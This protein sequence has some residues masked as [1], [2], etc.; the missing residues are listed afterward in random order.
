MSSAKWRPLCLSFNVLT[1]RYMLSHMRQ[2]IGLSMVALAIGLPPLPSHSLKKWPIVNRTWNKL[3]CHFNQDTTPFFEENALDN[4]VCKQP[5]FRLHCVNRPSSKCSDA[6]KEYSIN[7][8]VV[9]LCFSQGFM[10]SISRVS[11]SLGYTL[12]YWPLGV[13]EIILQVISWALPVKLVFGECPR[14]PL[15]ICQYWFR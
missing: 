8:H 12:T 11:G 13:M 7:V 15:M 10:Q 2:W 6:L 9:S 14:T 1:P 4:S 3:Q 5:F